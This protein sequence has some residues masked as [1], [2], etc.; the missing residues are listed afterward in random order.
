MV[1]GFFNNPMGLTNEYVF[2]NA[3]VA[4]RARNAMKAITGNKNG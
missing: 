1:G 4:K 3:Y 2:W